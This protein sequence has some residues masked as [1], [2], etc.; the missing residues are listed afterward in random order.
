MAGKV[1]VLAVA[2]VDYAG[3]EP[4]Q[5]LIAAGVV[6][7]APIDPSLASRIMRLRATDTQALG[8]AGDPQN[9]EDALG[10]AVFVDQRETEQR[11]QQHF[12]QA[13]GQLERF[14]EDKL[15]VCRRELASV[16]EKL[17]SAQVRRDAVVGFSAR[18]RTEEEIARLA[19][20]K[21]AL[22]Q[23]IEALDS[24]AD[25]VYRKWR[26]RYHELRYRAPSVNRLFQLEFRIVSANPRTS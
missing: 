6:D 19:K 20:Q 14:V 4:V 1:G 10:E 8:L 24:R 12:E 23:R 17:R 2:L 3:F 15:L 13:I 16:T 5:R 7:G 22:E 25:E 21:E 11:E 9:L 26:S 18:E